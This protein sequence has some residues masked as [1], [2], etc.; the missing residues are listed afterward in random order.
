MDVST[1]KPL[2]I[3]ALNKEFVS[4]AVSMRLD[5]DKLIIRANDEEKFLDSIELAATYRKGAVRVF[6][7]GDYVNG[8][9]L[10]LVIERKTKGWYFAGYQNLVYSALSVNDRFLTAKQDEYVTNKLTKW[11]VYG[12]RMEEMFCIPVSDT[13]KIDEILKRYNGR[14]HAHVHDS[15]DVRILAS[16]LSKFAARVLPGRIISGPIYV[17]DRSGCELPNAYQNTRNVSQMTLK[18]EDGIVS[19]IRYHVFNTWDKSMGKAQ[20]SLGEQDNIKAQ[21]VFKTWGIFKDGSINILEA[22]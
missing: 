20:Y 7:T 15:E 6:N 3:S 16:N 22:A 18:L 4:Q 13:G 11:S 14:N 8:M 9:P 10:V 17:Y 12:E 19:L 21:H 1:F 2:L 5:P